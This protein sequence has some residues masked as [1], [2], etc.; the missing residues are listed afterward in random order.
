MLQDTKEV[1]VAAVD[2]D[3]ES[4][5][6]ASERLKNDKNVAMLALANEGLQI[7]SLLSAFVC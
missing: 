5:F 3:G 2:N 1:V 4:L 6:F 7:F